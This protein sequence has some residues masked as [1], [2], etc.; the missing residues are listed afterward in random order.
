MTAPKGFESIEHS[1]VVLGKPLFRSKVFLFGFLPID[2]SDITLIEFE[3][4]SGFVEQSPMGSMKLWRHERR[5]IPTPGG[6]KIID[7]LTFEPKMASAFTGWFIRTVFK[8][9]HN[10]LRKNLN[11]QHG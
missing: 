6:C 1:N 10:V 2:Y 4:G 11:K 3:K 8:H 7:H 9:R 5:I